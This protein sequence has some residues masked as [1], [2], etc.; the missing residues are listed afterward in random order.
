MRTL[1]CL[2]TA[3]L[4]ALN[5]AT[6]AFAA[7]TL[8]Q[9]GQR[10]IL[11]NDLL[12]LCVNPA[13][14]GVI[15]SYLVKATGCELIGEGCF[16]LGDHFWQQLWPGEFLSAPY[17]AKVVAQTPE[18]VTLEVSCISKGWQDNAA[19]KD[20]KVIRR[21]T[22]RADSPLLLVEIAM[23]NIGNVGRVAGYW[24]Q[25]IFYAGGKKEEEHLFFRPTIRGVSVATYESTLDRQTVEMGTPD[26]FVR[27]V[28]QGWMA[29]LGAESRRGVAFVMKYDELMFLYNCLSHFTS[30]WQYKAV[31][32]PAGKTWKTDF[33]VYPIAGLPRVDYASR[34]LVAAVEP[35][36]AEGKLTVRL[37][38]AAAATKLEDVT[39]S[40]DALLVRDANRPSVPFAPQHVASVST[41]PTVFAFQLPHDPS[42][43]LALRFTVK[44]KLGGQDFQE[45]FETWYG[46]KYGRN[47][48]VDGSPLYVIPSPE[49]HVTFLKPDKIEKIHNEKP[50]VLLCKGMYAYE[51]L[52]DSIFDM[53]KAEV[54]S[55]YFTPTGTW[56]AALS[57]FPASYEELM[58][59]DVIA[60]INVDAAALGEVGQE[61]VKDFVTHGGT[62]VYG[63]D[64]WAYGRGNLKGGA[65][66]HLLPVSFP[67][68]R[69][70]GGL[71]FLKGQSVF[72]CNEAGRPR[73]PLA[74]NAVMV[75]AGD[76]F[77]V[78]DGAQVLLRCGD[79][80]VVVSWKMGQGRV[81]AI[82]GTVLGDAP[83][84]AVLFTRTPEWAA[85]IAD[86]LTDLPGFAR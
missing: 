11:E 27:D 77:T 67:N 45:R 19:Q 75:Y 52:P 14:G 83:A 28:Q 51:Y 50:R 73:R 13:R 79:V 9:E 10:Y 48:Q 20:I 41:T 84:G 56:P 34:R 42:E 63:G 81:I 43:P 8:T 18:A 85:L 37:H 35:S 36:D 58:A 62:L 4:V 76:T 7:V 38:L 60:L 5:S 29:A 74:K 86:L 23:E 31:G 55:S 54:T 2:L 25:N 12:R 16:M 53:M 78:K 65:L 80:P 30:E 33:V 61:M 39:V 44:A 69:Q 47:W 82:T 40:G 22:L 6:A 70:A 71:K 49:R 26:G 72:V 24:N 64:M 17:E 57:Y 32:I 3:M 21:M 15:D 66:A 59:L 68:D 46:A 1:I